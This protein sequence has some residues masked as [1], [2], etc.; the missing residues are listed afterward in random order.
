M[1]GEGDYSGETGITCNIVYRYNM[2]ETCTFF[3]I[4][5]YNTSMMMC[6]LQ[7][8]IWK[9]KLLGFLLSTPLARYILYRGSSTIIPR[10]METMEI[11]TRLG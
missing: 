5:I 8:G 6:N 10:C 4:F 7:F 9:L 3:E 2:Q 1:I 11:M